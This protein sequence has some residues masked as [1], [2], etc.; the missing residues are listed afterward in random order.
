MERNMHINKE[1]FLDYVDFRL[2]HWADWYVRGKTTGL[3]YPTCSVEFRLMLY[4]NL[5]Q[6]TKQVVLPTNEEAEEIENLIRELEGYDETMAQALRI[7]YI[8]K[9]YCLDKGN[10]IK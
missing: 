1:N 10:A 6:T 8:S 9:D 4:G 2:K 3:G 7:Q 5:I